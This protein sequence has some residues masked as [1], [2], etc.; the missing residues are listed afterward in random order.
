[1]TR[2]SADELWMSSAESVYDGNT[3]AGG[4]NTAIR[5]LG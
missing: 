2:L 3:C 5:K 4:R 1:M